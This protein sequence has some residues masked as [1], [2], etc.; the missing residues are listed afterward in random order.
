[1]ALGAA[2]A[3]VMRLVLTSHTRALAI[4]VVIGVLGSI[5]ASAVLQ[6]RLHGLSPFDP[7][8]YGMAALLLV[9]CGLAATIVPMRHATNTNPLETL[10]DV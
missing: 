7:V 5:A 3:A 4:G 6:N 2:P 1:M 9:L 10:R 8:T